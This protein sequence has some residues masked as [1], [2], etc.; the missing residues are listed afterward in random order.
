VLLHQ[1]YNLLLEECFV[2]LVVL[3]ALAL[4]L[5]TI[6]ITGI[7]PLEEASDV[8]RRLEAGASMGKLLLKI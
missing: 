1:F 8:H 3:S 4:D 2:L 6:D 7:F 5:F